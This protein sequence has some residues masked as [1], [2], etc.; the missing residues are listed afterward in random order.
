LVSPQGA[1]VLGGEVR[2]AQDPRG[3]GHLDD[4]LLVANRD[5]CSSLG[6]IS[7]QREIAA[8]G[9]GV[10]VHSKDSSHPCLLDMLANEHLIGVRVAAVGHRDDGALCAKHFRDL[11]DL[12]RLPVFF[13]R[14]WN[15]GA[16]QDHTHKVDILAMTPVQG[17]ND[18]L[19]LVAMR[20]FP[21]ALP[22]AFWSMLVSR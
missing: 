22:F 7:D 21:I 8:V 12:D 15:Q 17:P 3:G 1:F 5:D 10:L 6:Y 14:A 18:R 13:N 4:F 16:A 9:I 20:R 2:V 11:G 19:V